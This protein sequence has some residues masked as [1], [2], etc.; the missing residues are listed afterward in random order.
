LLLMHNKEGEK[1]RVAYRDT[2]Y[3]NTA[4]RT[5]AVGYTSNACTA[6]YKFPAE[7]LNVQIENTNSH[8]SMIVTLSLLELTQTAVQAAIY[9][10][11]GHCRVQHVCNPKKYQDKYEPQ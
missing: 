1:G 5:A 3:S 7:A 4:S 8:S 11:H 9:P 10:L 6:V 2:G